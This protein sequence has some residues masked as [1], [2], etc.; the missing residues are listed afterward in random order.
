MK[1]TVLKKNSVMSPGKIFLALLLISLFALFAALNSC[2]EKSAPKKNQEIIDKSDSSKISESIK[3]KDTSKKKEP[4]VIDTLKPKEIKRID[5]TTNYNSLGR[6]LSGLKQ[7]EA[8][9]I[10]PYEDSLTWIKYA[11][12][13]RS[14]WARLDRIKLRRMEKFRDVEF[15]EVNRNTEVLFYP[16]GGPDFLHAYSF[17][18]YAK[19]FVLIGL[20]SVGSLPGVHNMAGD[21]A[22]I[23]YFGMINRSLYTVLAVSFFKTIDMKEDFK[24]EELDG[25]LPILVIF[26]IRTDNQIVDIKPIFVNSAGEVRVKE[27]AE[28]A[29]AYGVEITFVDKHGENKTMYYFSRNISNSGF[30]PGYSFYK[31]AEKLGPVTTYLKAASYLMHREEQFSNIRDFILHQSKYVIEDDSGIPVKYFDGNKWDLTFYGAYTE[32]IKL[33]EERYQDTLAKIYLDTANIYPLPFGIGYKH[34]SG[35]SNMMLAKKKQ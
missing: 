32:P 31:F 26:C 25:I 34:R 30:K 23:K 1:S 19:K 8:N 2:D 21:S 13:N 22:M 20:E 17:F 4:R 28:F 6:F 35:T 16:F 24:S 7:K 33:F 5:I 14:K 11:K 3:K 10:T 29:D 27:K 12:T 18:P 15:A 9:E